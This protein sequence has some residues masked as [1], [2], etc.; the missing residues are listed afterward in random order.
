[1]LLFGTPPTSW[2]CLVAAVLHTTHSHLLVPKHI[3]SPD[4]FHAVIND[5]GDQD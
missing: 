2:T 4:A 1:M 3:K 5:G